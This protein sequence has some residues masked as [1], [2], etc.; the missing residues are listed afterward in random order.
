M[1][2]KMQGYWIGPQYGM[3]WRQGFAPVLLQWRH[4]LGPIPLIAP[5]NPPPTAHGTVLEYARNTGRLNAN[6]CIMR[7]DEG[8]WF[9]GKLRSW[10]KAQETSFILSYFSSIGL[11]PCCL[12]MT[13][14]VRKVPEKWKLQWLNVGTS[15]VN[16]SAVT[17]R[18][19]RF[20]LHS[21]DSVVFLP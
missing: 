5:L 7:A 10:M 13:T 19:Y 6:S 17:Y 8:K 14:H 18:D 15:F 9:V 1:I 21:K 11:R 16:Q 3:V 4:F 2:Q 12:L 20:V